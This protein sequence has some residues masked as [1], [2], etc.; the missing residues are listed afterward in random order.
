[1]SFIDN[2]N[3]LYVAFTR[4][5]ESLVVLAPAPGKPEKE[6]SPDS[7]DKLM[8]NFFRELQNTEGGPE[9]LVQYWD[10]EQFNFHYGELST[11][12]GAH[13]HQSTFE[14]ET[15]DTH[16]WQPRISFRRHADNVF[17]PD[18][19]STRASLNRGVIIHEI[20]S[21]IIVKEDLDK[22]LQ[23]AVYTGLTGP[24]DSAEIK[25]L[26]LALL[27]KRELSDW[28]SGNWKVKTEVPVIPAPGEL[29]RM[30]RV[31]FRGKEVVV[32]DY[33][34]GV[35]RPED[36]KQ[37]RDYMNILQQMDYDEVSGYLLYTAEG[38]LEKV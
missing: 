28:F 5:V 23:Q 1:M 16:E 25:E 32:L 2:L 33:K 13:D 24:E 20:L 17:I 26:I 11:M 3:L 8:F 38:K 35:P 14:L 4:A 6:I 21:E 19:S 18:K 27:N 31:M 29:S 34:T 30:D 10:K 12:Q 7:A 37:V 15:L 22:A 36:K 9:D